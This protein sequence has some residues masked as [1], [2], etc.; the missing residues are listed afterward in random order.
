[1]WVLC[2][3]ASPFTVA[4]MVLLLE[5]VKMS[6]LLVV[7]PVLIL[8][9]GFNIDFRVLLKFNGGKNAGNEKPAAAAA[10]ND[11]NRAAECSCALRRNSATDVVRGSLA[12]DV[13]TFVNADERFALNDEID[14]VVDDVIVGQHEHKPGNP[15]QNQN[16]V[17][18][19]YLIFLVKIISKGW[20]MSILR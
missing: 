5:V 14:D 17:G 8:K 6:L 9:L 10:C 7:D 18:F 12:D 11:C 4:E 15:A 13:E 16:V 2:C 20:K 1:M 3:A 19:F